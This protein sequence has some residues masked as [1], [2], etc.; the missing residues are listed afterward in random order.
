MV[1]KKIRNSEGGVSPRQLEIMMFV[2][3]FCC[4]LAQVGLMAVFL[5]AQ[6]FDT[7][8]LGDALQALSIIMVVWLLISGARHRG[9]DRPNWWRR[10]PA[11]LWVADGGVIILAILALMALVMIGRITGEASPPGHYVPIIA[12]VIA[13]ICFSY[14]VAWRYPAKAGRFSGPDMPPPAA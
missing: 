7:Q 11:W 10:L 12:S 2:S 3:G 9:L 1:I 5:G 6:S 13:V 14:C 8:L 4:V